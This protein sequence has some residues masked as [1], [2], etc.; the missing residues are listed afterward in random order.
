MGKSRNG[1][2]TENEFQSQLNINSDNKAKIIESDEESMIIKFTDSQRY[3]EV[4]KEGHV[5]PIEADGQEKYLTVQC[6]NSQNM[7]LSEQRYLILKNTYS[8]TAPQIDEYE[9]AGDEILTGAITEDTTIQVLYYLKCYDDK[10]LV[11]TGLDSSGNITTNESEITSYMVGDRSSTYGNAMREKTIK[12]VLYIPDKY[13]GK[14]V[15]KVG[16]YSF[17]YSNN[18]MQATIGDN[19]NKI[20]IWAFRASKMSNLI[21]GKKVQSIGANSFLGCD[22]LKTITLKSNQLSSDFHQLNNKN[23]EHIKIDGNEDKFKVVDNI[24]YSS[25]GKILIWCP[26]SRKGTLVLPNGVEEIKERA[27]NESKLSGIEISDSIKNIGQWSFNNASSLESIVIGINVVSISNNNTFKDCS[28]LNTVVIRSSTIANGITASNSYGKL[29]S[30]AE[31]I[32][33]NEQVTNIGSYILENY[34]ETTSDKAAYKKYI[35]K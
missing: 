33:I 2:F 35:K 29:I 6:I 23:I 1:N 19:I 32:Y 18:L 7:V 22:D 34:T 4:S 15:V 28:K 16:Q 20:D 3:Y 31:K 24:L 5:S 11:F 21:I 13:K 26:S 8:K 30:W 25:D 12:S 14:D 9:V 17:G 27:F 10:T